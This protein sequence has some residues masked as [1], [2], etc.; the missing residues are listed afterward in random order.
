MSLLPDIFACATCMPD[1]DSDVAKASSMAILFMV[2]VVFS[3]LGLVIKIMFNFA[4]K[5]RE[6][7]SLSK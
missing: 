7:S 2:G 6:H 1:P 3:M 4:R 5:E